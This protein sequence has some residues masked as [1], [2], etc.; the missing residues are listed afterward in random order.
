MLGRILLVTFA[1]VKRRPLPIAL[2]VLLGLA[3]CC[4][5][6]WVYF[7]IYG[8]SGTAMNKQALVQVYEAADPSLAE[9]SRTSFLHKLK[10]TAP[11]QWH[12][13]VWRPHVSVT[14]RV[15]VVTFQRDMRDEPFVYLHPDYHSKTSGTVYY[16]QILHRLQ[17]DSVV[18]TDGTLDMASG[19]LAMWSTTLESKT[20]DPSWHRLTNA[21]RID[22]TFGNAE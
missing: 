9:F 10:F 7:G 16:F 20:D 14:S 3:V 1:F 2:T 13:A 8:H 4:F 17:N 11:I 18:M 12:R 6:G 5:Y 22:F 21:T 19:V 15:D